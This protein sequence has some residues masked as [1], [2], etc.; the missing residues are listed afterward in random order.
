MPLPHSRSGPHAANRTALW[1]RKAS[2]FVEKNLCPFEA[3]FAHGVVRSG[4]LLSDDPVYPAGP[5][6]AE[7]SSL[8][9]RRT[10][11]ERLL[12]SAHYAADTRD[13]PD[14]VITVA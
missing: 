8:R 7:T 11:E 9:L 1:N 12:R 6:G 13:N 14:M 4:A 10:Q 5:A 2:S 3:F